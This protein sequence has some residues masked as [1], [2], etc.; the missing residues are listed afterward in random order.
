M[1]KRLN[2]RTK[3]TAN[4]L[5]SLGE[6]KNTARVLAALVG[7][8][9]Q[10]IEAVAQRSGYNALTAR[11]ILG[12]LITRGWVTAKRLPGSGRGP[13]PFGYTLK[14]ARVSMLQ[15]YRAQALRDVTARFKAVRPS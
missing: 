14:A 6:R 10:R 9:A 8:G 2:P 15:F 1:G 7:H 5:M 4:A 12:G 11:K 13:R 3:K